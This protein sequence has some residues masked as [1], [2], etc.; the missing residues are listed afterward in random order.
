MECSFLTLGLS[1][2]FLVRGYARLVSSHPGNRCV[3]AAPLSKM[4]TGSHG[5]D[6]ESNLGHTEKES[7]KT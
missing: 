1:I 3:F 5:V 2:V 4:R 6:I 7:T